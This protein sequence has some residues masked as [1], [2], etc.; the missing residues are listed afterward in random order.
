LTT[1]TIPASVTSIGKYAFF[2]CKNL[3]SIYVNWENPQNVLG[4]EYIPDTA[5]IYMP[6]G[7]KVE[8]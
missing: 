7:M 6:D 1:I 2:G 8:V 5:T 4:L 3:T